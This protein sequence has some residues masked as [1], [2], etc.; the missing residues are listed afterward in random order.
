[1]PVWHAK[2]KRLQEEGKIQVVGIIQEQHP[3]RCALYMQW[4]QMGW[5]VL[6]DAL[7]RTG[8]HAVPR[9]WAIDEHGVLRKKL[10]NPKRDMAWLEDE[11][12]E[13]AY[14]K[15]DVV[16]SPDPLDTATEAFLAGK[17]DLAISRF[18]K[19]KDVEDASTAAK[20]W[21]G[22]GC[23]YR[24]RHD[25][26]GRQGGDFQAAIHAWTQALAKNPRNYIYRRRLQQYGP[27]LLKPYPFYDW[28]ETAR[29]EITARGETPLPLLAEP[30]GAEIARP[31]RNFVEAGATAAKEPDPQA[32]LP[33]DTAGLIKISQA[34]APM[35]ANIGGTARV[36]VFL[37]P[38]AKRRVTWDNAAGTTQIWLESPQGWQL[39]ER[40]MTA[41]I[42]SKKESSKED[43]RFEFE[44]RIPADAKAG[45][46]EIKGYALY[47]VCDGVSGLCTYLRQDFVLPIQHK[48]KAGRGQRGGRR[49]R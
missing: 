12:L 43:R 19:E 32:K 30:E 3:D 18:S 49:R 44:V 2:T 20:A 47:Y 26:K 40:L 8:V 42:A 34:T 6:V 48:K 9:A 33:L 7:N 25:S 36:Y 11:F 29:L 46:T 39:T 1:M 31:S 38:N 15:P 27:R 4:Q 37:T 45:T 35:P 24:A 16:A 14:E 10:R 5:P 13:T 21:F 22:I 17:W 41:K 28:I 23:S